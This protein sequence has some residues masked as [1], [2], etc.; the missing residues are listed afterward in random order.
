MAAVDEWRKSDGKVKIVKEGQKQKDNEEDGVDVLGSMDAKAFL[1]SDLGIGGDGGLWRDP[2]S[3]NFNDS[4]PRS[5]QVFFD[6]YSIQYL[7]SLFLCI[8]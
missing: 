2:F 6:K 3:M 4:P 8:H 5:T 7:Y 1:Q